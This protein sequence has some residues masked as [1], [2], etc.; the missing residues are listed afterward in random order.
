M[1]SCDV[2]LLPKAGTG[3]GF[4]VERAEEAGAASRGGCLWEW[5]APRGWDEKNI[6]FAILESRKLLEESL[7]AKCPGIH[8]KQGT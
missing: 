1:T 8:R 5:A 2:G 4:S 6:S 3:R 7:C